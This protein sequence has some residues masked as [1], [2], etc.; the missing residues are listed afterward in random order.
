M[1]LFI[2]NIFFM[3]KRNDLIMKLFL[4]YIF[5]KV[6]T[7]LWSFVDVQTVLRYLYTRKVQPSLY[8]NNSSA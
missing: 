3:L 1:T 2:K 4:S 5:R 7:S 8:G 6:S